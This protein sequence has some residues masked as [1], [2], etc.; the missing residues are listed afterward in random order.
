MLKKKWY[1]ARGLYHVSPSRV[2]HITT[3]VLAR[4]K[5]GAKRKAK[6]EFKHYHYETLIVNKSIKEVKE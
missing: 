6:K 4:T 5:F 2:S 1:E 3:Y